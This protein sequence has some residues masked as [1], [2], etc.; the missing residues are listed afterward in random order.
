MKR[1]VV[2]P[3]DPISD[4]EKKGTSSWLE[5]YF[6]PNKYFNEVYV[7]SPLEKVRTQKYGLNIIPV[8]S[9]KKYRKLIREINPS[10]VRAY[11][12]FWAT[13]FA[14]FNYVKGVPVISSV[15][16]TNPQLIHESLSFSDQCI[17][18]S[19]VLQDFLIKKKLKQ[20]KD[21]H[22]L[23]NRVDTSVFKKRPRDSKILGFFPEGKMILHIGRK[24]HQKNIDNVIKSL[25]YLPDDYYLILIGLGDTEKYKEIAKKENINE[26]V[27][28][29]DSVENNI[30]YKYYSTADV[31]CVPSRW[32]G[33]GMVFIE[34]ASC[35]TK[36]VSSNI[37]PMNEYLLNDG[38]MNLLIDDYENPKVISEAIIRILNINETNKNTR[39][40]IIKT[41][42]K[43]I[44]ADKE[45]NIYKSSIDTGNHN[46]L[47]FI[48]WK[49]SYRYN[50]FIKPVVKKVKKIPKRVW[51]RIR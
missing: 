28:W 26:R 39:D 51:R 5:E 49:W 41:F 32:E 50:Y 23:G 8:S 37:A 18:M 34:A 47:R 24:T 7:L 43:K 2:I 40:Y 9:N 17:V 10:C 30:L 11:G 27:F 22:V 29:L 46:S 16:D 19:N 35:Q 42:D 31:L 13:D 36:I 6:N 45:I 15:H 48:L 3:S 44:I 12:G 1:L 38:I 4:Y 14:N 20:Q 33:F 21:I 25:K